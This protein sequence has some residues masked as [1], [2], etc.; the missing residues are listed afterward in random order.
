MAGGNPS[1]AP[2][3]SERWWGPDTVA[4]VTGANK[5]IGR[6]VA[7]LLA[8]QG[9]RVVLTARQAEAGEEAAA[10]LRAAGHPSVEF[11]PLDIA[12]RESVEAFAAWARANLPCITILVNNAGACQL[13]CRRW[14]QR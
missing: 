8:E 10:A 1:G 6:E 2:V 3:A 4:V 14:A 9:L 11:A 12:S 13:D 7:R 5:G